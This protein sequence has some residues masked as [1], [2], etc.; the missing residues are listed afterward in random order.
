MRVVNNNQKEKREL[1]RLGD[2]SQDR[3]RWGTDV[4][5]IDRNW[6]WTGIVQANTLVMNS[7]KNV[8][9]SWYCASSRTVDSW[10]KYSSH[11]DEAMDDMDQW[12][13]KDKSS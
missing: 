2:T 7:P 1:P 8:K 10:D 9:R 6:C 13:K 4:E 5:N 3:D 11:R 12:T